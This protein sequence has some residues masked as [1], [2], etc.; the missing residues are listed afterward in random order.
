MAVKHIDTYRKNWPVA[1]AGVLSFGYLLFALPFHAI[2]AGFLYAIRDEIRPQE[3][4]FA[5]LIWASLAMA[6]VLVIYSV[7]KQR[8]NIRSFTSRFSELGFFDAQPHNIMMNRSGL[9][10]LGLDTKKGILLYINHPETT[11]F[12]FFFPKDIRVMGFGMYDWKSVEVEGNTLRIYTGIPELPRIAI[13]H[14]NAAQMYEKINAMRHQNWTYE[15]NIPGY[16]EYQATRIAEANNL[17]LVLP[18]K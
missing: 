3:V 16:V 1:Y 6:I 2:L 10:Y 11:V 9:G 4:T 14:G 13:A 5:L 17:N 8:R 12:N 15:N 18:P 7:L